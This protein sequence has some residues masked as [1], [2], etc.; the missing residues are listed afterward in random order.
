MRSRFADLKQRAN[1]TK[2]LKRI[3]VLRAYHRMTFMMER[4]RYYA[5]I[6]RAC[7]YPNQFLSVIADGTGSVIYVVCVT[8]RKDI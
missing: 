8:V 7:M 6:L 5:K 3:N 2:L 1:S 4:R